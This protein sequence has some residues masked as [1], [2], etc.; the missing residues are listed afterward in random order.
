MRFDCEI[1]QGAA[2]GFVRD[3]I[4]CNTMHWRLVVVAV[5]TARRVELKAYAFS[6][7]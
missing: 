4:F 2:A 3:A 7:S 6:L 5:D 1:M